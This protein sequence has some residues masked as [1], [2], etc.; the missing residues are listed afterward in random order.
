MVCT[1]CIRLKQHHSKAFRQ[2]PPVSLGSIVLLCNC[3]MLYEGK[4]TRFFLL[5]FLQ[6]MKSGICRH[7]NVHTLLF[8][9]L[10]L[11]RFWNSFKMSL[12]LFIKAAISWSK[13]SNIV[14][15][16]YI[17][18]MHYFLNNGSSAVN[19]CR[20]NYSSN[21]TII[22]KSFINGMSVINKSMKMYLTSNHL[23]YESIINNPFSSKKVF[24][25]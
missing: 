14:K 5:T 6:D 8:K 4:Q 19:G 21:I 22:H 7:R 12:L 16:Y 23:K 11:L 24:W 2:G 25:S 1:T 17:N 9:C 15:C 18:V 20:Q 13:Y 10:E 3:E